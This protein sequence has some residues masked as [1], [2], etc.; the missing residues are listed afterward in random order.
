M[1]GIIKRINKEG[2]H[3]KDLLMA[4]ERDEPGSSRGIRRRSDS[5]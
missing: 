5:L 1:S 2:F 3:P 4:D